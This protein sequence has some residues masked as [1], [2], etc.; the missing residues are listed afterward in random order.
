MSFELFN[1]LTAYGD[2]IRLNMER[3]PNI[4]LKG[5]KQFD[6]NWAKYN[7]RK[8]I[9]RFGLSVTNLDGTLGP[10]PDLDSLYEYNKEN[11]TNISESDFIVPTP[12]YDVVKFYCDPFKKWL[13]RSHILKLGPGGFF[14]NHTDNIG[15][16]INSFRL[17]VPLQV[18]DPKQ[19]AY[20]IYEQNKILFWDY[21]HLYF[22]N[23]CKRHVIF[24][25]NDR[26]NHIVLIMNIK[27]TKESVHKVT[28]LILQ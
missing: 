25:A 2:Q 7:P 24:N 20:F 16:T 14:P 13:L 3:D 23:T 26:Y 11:N 18:C 28:N 9:N 21:G 8:S 22:F 12:V 19:G 5:L 4:T 1:I 6:N 17:F 10:G 27:L 15:S